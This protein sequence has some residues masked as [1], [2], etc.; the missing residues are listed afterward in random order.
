MKHNAHEALARTT[1]DAKMRLAG[2]EARERGLI[3]RVESK[4]GRS[5]GRSVCPSVYPSV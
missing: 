2:Q 3:D 4:V 1:R 5:A